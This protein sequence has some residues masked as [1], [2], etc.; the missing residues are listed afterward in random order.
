[1]SEK[2]TD[3]KWR[4]D[5]TKLKRWQPKEIVGDQPAGDEKNLCLEFDKLLLGNFTVTKEAN[6]KL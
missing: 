6:P 5:L 3:E 1:M 4:I 2:V